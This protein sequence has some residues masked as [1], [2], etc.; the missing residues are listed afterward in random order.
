MYL[1]YITGAKKKK[2][3]RTYT[4][5]FVNAGIGAPYASAFKSPGIGF[6]N[7]IDSRSILALLKVLI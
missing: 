5:A 7:Y 1:K 2:K 6:L 4:S 3:K